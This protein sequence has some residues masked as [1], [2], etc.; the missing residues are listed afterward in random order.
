MKFNLKATNLELVAPIKAHVEE[1]FGGLDK[2]FDNIQNVDVE[3]GLVT[4]G[5]QKGKIYFCEVNV[6][7]PRKLLRFRKEYE[8]LMK[9]INETK[10]GIQQEIMKYKEML[11][12]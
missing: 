4:K 6:S 5:Q 11:R 3:I 8:D 12:G 9:A 7:V 2:Y 1:K 10:K